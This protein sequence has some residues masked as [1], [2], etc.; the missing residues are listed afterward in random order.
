MGEGVFGAVVGVAEEF[1]VDEKFDSATD[2]SVENDDGET[3]D[4]IDLKSEE[5]DLGGGEEDVGDHIEL[6]GVATVFWG[7]VL[8]ERPFAGA[9]AVESVGELGDKEN[10]EGVFGGR[11]GKSQN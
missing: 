9:G 1:A 6:D 3:G 8:G 7:F 10:D 11:A 2:E 5:G 4:E